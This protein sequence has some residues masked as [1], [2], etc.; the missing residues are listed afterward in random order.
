MKSVK[1]REITAYESTLCEMMAANMNR[2]SQPSS[3]LEP[4]CEVRITREP[5][6][7]P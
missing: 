6:V 3:I 7:R 4:K 5:G 1:V 2:L